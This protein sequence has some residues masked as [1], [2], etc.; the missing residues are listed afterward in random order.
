MKNLNKIL[1][2]TSEFPPLPGGIGNHAFN[3][4]LQLSKHNYQVTIIADHRS[5]NIKEEKDFDNNLPFKVIRVKRYKFIGIT[6]L[7]RILVY[8]KCLKKHCKVIA[9]GKFP[10]W[11]TGLDFFTRGQKKVAVI[12]GTEVN[13]KGLKK[14]LTNYSLKK[15]GKVIAVSNYTKSLV[16]NLKLSAVDVIFNGFNLVDDLKIKSRNG[17]EQ[18]S[19]VNLITVGKVSQRKGQLNVIKS[20]PEIVKQ[21]FKVHFHIVGIPEE[22]EEFEVIARNLGVFKHMTFYGKVSEAKKNELLQSSQI[23]MMLSNETHSG[24]VEGFGIAIIEANALGL[25]AIGS[26]NCGIE[27]AIK[28]KFS[29]ILVDPKKTT[30]IVLAIEEIIHDY[31]RYSCQATKWSKEFTW[32]KVINNYIEILDK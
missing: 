8:K 2:F 26:V 9:T 15:M 19:V 5:E 16:S 11:V 29:G 6:Y 23:F 21:G 14:Y 28:N 22:K 7:K 27:D 12:H 30:E 3:L 31:E 13:F 18:S 24:D 10:L 17:L 25:P 20:I 1:I 4:G 32:E